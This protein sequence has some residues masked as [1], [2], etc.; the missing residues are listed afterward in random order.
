MDGMNLVA[1]VGVVVVGVLG[2]LAFT[3]GG[4]LRWESKTHAATHKVEIEG[5][6]KRKR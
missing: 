3:M 6:V 4:R 2:V 1:L 5:G